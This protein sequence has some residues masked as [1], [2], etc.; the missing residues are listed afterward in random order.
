MPNYLIIGANS[1]MV[2]EFLIDI[3]KVNENRLFLFVNDLQKFNQGIALKLNMNNVQVFKCNLYGEDIFDLIS[4][5]NVPIDAFCYV[6]GMT[7]LSLVKF[8]KRSD[9]SDVFEINFF[10]PLFIFQFL[11][12]KKL[13]APKANFVFISS[14]S[15]EGKVAPG[16]SSYSTSKAA[17]NNLVKVMSLECKA[18][19]LKINTVCPGVVNTAF[20]VEVDKLKTSNDDLLVSRYPLGI[21]VPSDVSS[22]IKYLMVENTWMTGQN[23]I[24]DGGFNIN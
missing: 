24:I 19:K 4:D 16:I 12:R 14:I 11:L 6:A 5:I 9:I 17:L 8:V 2:E 20:N 13:I 23:L 21:G 18:L 15:G 1:S 10:K 22:L 7:N 3:N